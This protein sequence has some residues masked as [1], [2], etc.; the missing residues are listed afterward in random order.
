[1]L[2]LLRPVEM[3]SAAKPTRLGRVF[4]GGAPI[5]DCVQI[6]K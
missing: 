1:V 6:Y 2:D 4:T 5:I 3:Q